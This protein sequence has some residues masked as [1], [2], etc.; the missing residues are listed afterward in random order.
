MVLAR[1][2]A[3]AV[4]VED[5]MVLVL[6][7]WRVDGRRAVHRRGD[8]M[9]VYRKEMVNLGDIKVK[10]CHANGVYSYI[11]FCKIRRNLTRSRDNIA[12]SGRTRR[13]KT[14]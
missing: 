7:R 8:T 4:L 14:C 1:F 5:R 6:G 2:L 3:M 10:T 12:F 11:S 13:L 9:F